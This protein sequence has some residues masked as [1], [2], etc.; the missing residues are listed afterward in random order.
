MRFSRLFVLSIP[1]VPPLAGLA[2][3]LAQPWDDMSVKHAWKAVPDNWESLGPPLPGTEIDLYVALEP[4]NES[5]LVDALYDV[6]TPGNPKYGSHLSKEEVAKLV[7]PHPDTLELVHSWLAHHGVQSSSISTSHGGSW[8]TVTGVPVSRANEILGASYQ[9]YRHAGTNN[10]ILRTVGYALPTVLHAHVQTV[11][12]TTYFAPPRTFQQT[13]HRHPVGTAGASAK[14]ALREPVT[15]LPSRDSQE[16]TPEFL[17][18]LY[19]TVYY[20]PVA[21]S[22]NALGITGYNNE[23]P[24]PKDLTAFMTEFCPG[25]ESATFTVKRINGGGFD[26]KKPGE[27]ASLNMQYAQAI[28]YPTPHTFYSIG[29]QIMWFDPSGKPTPDDLFASW[30]AYVLKLKKVPQTISISYGHN[31]K[32][33][34][35]E[36]AKSICLLFAQLGLRG[37]SVLFATGDHGVGE[38]PCTD[39]SGRVQ[40]VPTFPATC[41]YVTSVGGTT[42]SRPEI[43]ANFSTGGFSNYFPIPPYQKKAVPFFLR[44]LGKKYK[45]MYNRKGRGIPDIAAQASRYIIIM[46]SNPFVV[47]GTSAAAPTMAGIISLLN[48]FLISQGKSPLG[49]LNPLLYGYA[50]RGFHDITSGTNPGCGTKGFSAIVGWDPVTG[51]GTPDFLELQ[52][53]LLST[54]IRPRNRGRTFSEGLLNISDTIVPT[55]DANE[56][57]EYFLI[58][59]S[60]RTTPAHWHKQN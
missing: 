56:T 41:P 28:A 40:F 5:A 55:R 37:V 15:V 54:V 59:S 10:T 14:T 50:I 32:D 6:S 21:T 58:N 1:T 48:D 26:P 19:K 17:R 24:S 16:V 45:G 57:D 13:P 11:A 22:K 3:P 12:P 52:H 31:E 9:L 23:F 2:T 7:E 44:R 43:A 49:F 33:Y 25:A 35:L 20:V 39:G 29:G 27:E 18:L 60:T 51:L 30:L 53:V 47:S 36:Y 38:E 46:N 34:P 42:S 8:L 4:H